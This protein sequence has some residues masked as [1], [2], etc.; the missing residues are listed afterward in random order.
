MI[1]SNKNKMFRVQISREIGK[2]Q[3]LKKCFSVSNEVRMGVTCFAQV[4]ERDL[5]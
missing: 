3:W 2:G 1:R 4:S 5:V